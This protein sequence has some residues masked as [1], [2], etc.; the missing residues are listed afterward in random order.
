MKTIGY[1]R[2][3]WWHPVL[4]GLLGAVAIALCWPAW[5]DIYHIGSTDEEQSH[6]LLVPIVAGWMFWARRLRLRACPP[7]GTFVGPCVVLAGWVAS[8]VGFNY[9]VQ[10]LW[11]AGAVLMFMGAILTVLGKNVLFQFLP[12]FVVLAF[13]VPIP[14]GIRQQVSMPLQTATAVVTQF[15]LETFG[16]PLQRSG[17]VLLIN[18]QQVAVAEACNGMRM[19]FALVLVSYAFAFAL[20]LRAG[21]RALVLLFSPVAALICNVIRLIPTVLIYGYSTTANGDLFHDWS[22]WLMLPVAFF[23]LLG[24]LKV[25]KWALLPVMRYNL[26]YQ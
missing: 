4:A 24:V 5:Q 10:S 21:T 12:A 20:P 7:A 16:T 17:N 15:V 19:V 1:E 26:A 18:G 11:H 25:L 8:V 13:L 6:V 14:G 2:W 3:Q 23:M 9:A 22:G